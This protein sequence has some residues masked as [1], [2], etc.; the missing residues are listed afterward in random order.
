M[1]PVLLAEFLKVKCLKYPV[2]V[3]RKCIWIDTPHLGKE[4]MNKST[5]C[6]A[7]GPG[8]GKIFYL[9][10]LEINIFTSYSDFIAFFFVV[11]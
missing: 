10:I 4:M 8:V 1:L 9:H 11:S 2:T 7:I 5:E 6:Q 3:T